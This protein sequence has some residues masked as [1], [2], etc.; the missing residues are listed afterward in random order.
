MLKR[1]AITGPES[2][3]KSWLAAGLA[4]RY[5]EFRVTEQ[6]RDYLN[7]LGRSYDF[8][9]ILEIGR[10]QYREEERLAA[11]AGEWL[12]CDTDFLVLRI[13][14]LVK[15]GRSHPW[16]DT[17][18]A[19]HTYH[20]YLLCKPDLPWED[21]PLREH[22]H[23]REQLFGMY[24]HELDERGLPYSVVSGYGDARLMRAVNAINHAGTDRTA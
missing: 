20:H 7:Q 13:W 10:L 6:A 12:F 11:L 17:M 24:L 8:N 23:L 3:G 2:T 19:Q 1:I 22:P 16:I 4:A 5:R 14:S 9:D 15:Y 18:V 21:D